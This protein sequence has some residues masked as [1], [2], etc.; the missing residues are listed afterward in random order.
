[1]IDIAHRVLVAIH[2]S[3]AYVGVLDFPGDEIVI[4]GKRREVTRKFRR[5]EIFVMCGVE[6]K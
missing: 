6:E 3:Q 5:V 2:E 1:M 4:I